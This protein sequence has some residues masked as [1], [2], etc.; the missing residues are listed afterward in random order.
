MDDIDLE[1]LEI[2]LDNLFVFLNNAEHDRKISSENGFCAYLKQGIEKFDY[3]SHEN[4][5]KLR[6]QSIVES[7]LT[8]REVS[9][10][11]LAMINEMVMDTGTGENESSEEFEKVKA[12]AKDI[13]KALG[14]DTVIKEDIGVSAI[15][16]GLASDIVNHVDNINPKLA[17]LQVQAVSAGDKTADNINQVLI[18]LLN[19]LVLPKNIQIDRHAITRSLDRPIGGAEQWK[20]VIND[21]SAL[22][23]KSIKALQEEKDELQVFIKKTT[24]Q[25]EAIEEYVR[26]SRQERIDTASESSMLK[27]SVDA[28]VGK[29]QT[30]VGDASD[31]N[32]LKNIVQVHLTEIRKSVE[33]HQAAE[34]QRES[35]SKQGYAHII[36]ELA[37]TQKETL[38]LKEQL[39]ES[40]RMMLRDPLTGLPNRLAYEERIALEI[41]RCK[42]NR[43]DICIAMWDIDHFKKVND[44]YGHDAGDRVLR[45]LSKIITTRVRKIDMFARI[46]GEEF[47]L[48]MLDANLENALFLNNQ[49][50]NSLADSNFHYDGSP[51]PITASVGI[52]KIEEYDNAE[53]VMRKADQALYRSKREG[54]NRCTIFTSED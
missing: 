53:S 11:L 18:Q 34:L 50:R 3:S 25:L 37:R 9:T 46:G 15:L 20:A 43:N 45:L 6:L 33:E 27:E 17:D 41:N 49:L 32:Q 54:R 16:D 44:T 7:K 2:Q 40:K 23:N 28:N 52:S 1:Q 26:R 51:C 12:F 24:S 29:I 19:N 39:Q 38:M 36:S 10:Q 4:P 14:L 35:M 13:I 47:V 22:I 21:M 30:T 31:L 8:D 42:R 48:L 5:Y